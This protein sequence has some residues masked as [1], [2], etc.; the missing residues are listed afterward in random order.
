MEQPRML[1]TDHAL[2][3]LLQMAKE[4][5]K[6]VDT[7]RTLVLKA[8]SDPTIFC[9]FDQ[10][11]ATLEIT[12]DHVLGRTLDLFSYG[13]YSE[14]KS[15]EPG[16]F[17]SFSDA[18]VFKLRQLTVLSLVQEACSQASSAISY[19]DLSHAL[20]VN[21]QIDVVEDVL[22][23]CIYA[24]V[25]AGQLCQKSKSFLLSCTMPYRSRDVPRTQTK[26]LLDRLKQF[27]NRLDETLNHVHAAKL[28]A[29]MLKESH[30]AFWRQNEGNQKAGTA[31]RFALRTRDRPTVRASNKR[32]RGGFADIGRF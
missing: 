2:Q 14:Y 9:G 8:L 12:D 5:S 15:A 30:D 26:N 18:H 16:H 27:R 29:Q 1:D 13:T 3:P 32:S 10:I 23:S 22:V 31:D 25:V 7:N 4:S 17:I 20:D 28:E 24:G 19:D 11:K 6:N 21:N